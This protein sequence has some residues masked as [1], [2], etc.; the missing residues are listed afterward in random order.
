MA[1]GV[2]GGVDME[3]LAVNANL[4]YKGNYLIWKAWQD[5]T[6]LVLKDA[7]QGRKFLTL[8]RLHDIV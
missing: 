5:L 3:V 8:L 6:Y 4:L 1:L 2:N 7:L